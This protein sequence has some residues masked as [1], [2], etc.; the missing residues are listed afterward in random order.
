MNTMG[1]PTAERGVIAAIGN[2]PLIKL[3]ALTPVGSA[4][5]YAKLE[6]AN[7]GGSI[8]DRPALY[9]IIKALESGDLTPGKTILEPTSGNTGIGLAMVGTA[10]GY[11]VKLC[12]PECVSIERR[13]LLEIFGAELILTPG[14][15]GTDGAIIK[16]REL[17]DAEPALYYMPDQFSNPCNPLSHYETTAVEILDQTGGNITAFVAGI[18]T[19]GTLMGTATRLR[20]HNP[21]IKIFGVEPVKGHAIQGLKNM[22]ESM[23]PDLYNPSLLDDIISVNDEEA[24]EGCRSLVAG[25][26]LFYGMSSGAAVAASLRVA[27]MLRNGNVITILPDRG[28]RYLSTALYKSVCAKCPP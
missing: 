27:R 2:T 23:V 1:T 16:A 15:L 8:K 3:S 25:E 21:G 12:M 7:P 22:S 26:G 4:G 10:L 9:M 11:R 6:G 24:C 20:E 14:H 18:G 19:T 28:E 13:A 5:I 17:R